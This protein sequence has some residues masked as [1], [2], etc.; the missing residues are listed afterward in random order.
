MCVCVKSALSG[1]LYLYF[2]LGFCILKTLKSLL[3]AELAVHGFCDKT[4]HGLVMAE[5]RYFRPRVTGSTGLGTAWHI[6]VCCIRSSPS[7]HW[8]GVRR[9]GGGRSKTLENMFKVIYLPE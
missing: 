7:H 6:A 2:C 3:S 9:V 8:H 1:L 5:G 4:F